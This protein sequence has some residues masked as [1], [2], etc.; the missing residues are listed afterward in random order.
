VFFEMLS[1]Q[2]AT[3]KQ[4]P[5]LKPNSLRFESNHNEIRMQNTANSYAQ[6]EQFK[7]LVSKD[8]HL[9]TGAMNGNE[10]KG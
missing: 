10:D 6:I 1:G 8:F 9:D 2:Q 3:F 7:N 4:I 5:N